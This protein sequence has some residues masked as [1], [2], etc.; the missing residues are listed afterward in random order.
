L[1]I[2]IK[3]H[4]EAIDDFSKLNIVIETIL[5]SPKAGLSLWP[6]RW[7]GLGASSE[8]V[9]LTRY[10]GMKAARVFRNST[11]A[12]SFDAFHLKVKSIEAFLKKTQRSVAVKNA[13][14]A[15]QAA[16]EVPARGETILVIDLVVTDFSDHPPRGYELG[17]RGYEIYTNGNL[18]AKIPPR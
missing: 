1:D 11:D 16:F 9:D 18:R 8:A 6:S 12:G 14:A 4:R 17:I 5:I 2:R 10:V 7:K 13:V 15:V 3:D